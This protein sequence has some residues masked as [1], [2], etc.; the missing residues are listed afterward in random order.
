MMELF[1]AI[2][3]RSG[4]AVRLYQGD[5]NQTTV[6]SPDP[7]SGRRISR[8]RAPGTST[9]WTWTEPRTAH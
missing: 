8:P 4:Q 6:Y 9:W 2:D 5:Y 3:L 7:V 1:P